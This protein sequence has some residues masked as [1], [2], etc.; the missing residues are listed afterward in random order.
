VPGCNH[1]DL[2]AHGM[3]DDPFWRLNETDLQWID[4]VDWEYEMEFQVESFTLER[5]RVSVHFQGLDTY[6]DV[7]VNGV[8]VL[9]ADNMFRDWWVDVK[10]HLK[11]GTN[12]L[13][14]LFR[15]PIVEGIKKYDALDY[16][17]PS[18]FTDQGEHG[19]VEGGKRV[20]VHTRKPGY[21]YGWD[22][23]VCQSGS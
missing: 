17:V 2:L 5:D 19:E 1:T 18:Q 21:H 20:S 7:R 14:L 16:V 22:F 9:S 10:S 13:H 6:A 15:S 12:R 8:L 23:G 11:P 3:I 4:K